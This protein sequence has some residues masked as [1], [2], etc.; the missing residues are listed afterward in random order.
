MWCKELARD[1][2]A[3]CT[4]GNIIAPH[5]TMWIYDID[6]IERKFLV[7]DREEWKCA[8][9]EMSKLCTYVRVKD[10]TEVGTL[11]KANLPR[12][13]RSLMARFLCGILPLQVETGRFSNVKKELCCCKVCFGDDI[14]DEIHFLLKCD[15]LKPTRK[16]HV[17][18]L[19]KTNV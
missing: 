3:I 4:E 7:K 6:P 17:K 15:K 16:T 8:A 13:Q 11:V 10:F 18:P 5:N 19:L 14:E 2:K 9:E 1:I 12:N